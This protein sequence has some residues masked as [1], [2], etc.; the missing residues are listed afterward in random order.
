MASLTGKFPVTQVFLAFSVLLCQHLLF[1]VFITYGEIS[2]KF[3]KI[4][5]ETYC[6]K[7]KIL[8][9]DKATKQAILQKHTFSSCSLLCCLL[10]YCPIVT[11]Q[12]TLNLEISAQIYSSQLSCTNLHYSKIW[13]RTVL[14]KVHFITISCF[15]QSPGI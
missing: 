1:Y 2:I 5:W 10:P 7:S 4:P 15:F 9:E 11:L 3:L 8:E 14:L 12:P 6:Q 13:S